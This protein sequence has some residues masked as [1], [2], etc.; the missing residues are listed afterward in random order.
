MIPF[1][2]PGGQAGLDLARRLFRSEA[3]RRPTLDSRPVQRIEPPRMTVRLASP[4]RLRWASA[5]LMV[6]R[7]PSQRVG[8]PST[9]AASAGLARVRWRWSISGSPANRTLRVQSQSWHFG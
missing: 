8:R 5:G 7:Q 4:S 6:P 1:T 2:E 9:R 3:L